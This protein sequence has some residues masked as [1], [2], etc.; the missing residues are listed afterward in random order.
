MKKIF[1]KIT[2]LLMLGASLLFVAGCNLDIDPSDSLT[3]DKMKTSPNGLTDVVNGCYTVFKD[4]QTGQGS[5]NWYLRQYYQLADF[6]SDDIVYGHETE[7]NLNMIFRYPERIASLDNFTTFWTNSYKIIYSANVA[8]ALASSA[9]EQTDL[10]KH[11]KG[12]A[13]FLKAYAMH[14]LVRLYAKPYTQVNPETD[15]GIIIRESTTD[16]ANKNRATLKETYDYIL[17]CLLEA[18]TTMDGITSDRDDSKGNVS[19]WAVRAELSRVYLYMG[20][21]DKAKEYATKVIESGKF[22][23]ETPA[24][25]PGYVTDASS[26]P[27]TIWCIKM[28][29]SDDKESGSVASMIMSEGDGCWGEEGYS[30]SLLADMGMGTNAQKADKRFQF[31]QDPVI[32]NGLTLYPCS[33]YS[34][35]DGKKTCASP[36]MIR[37]SEMYFNRAEA[38]ANTAAVKDAIAD[39][40]TV[41]EQRIDPTAVPG[42]KMEDYL[43][44]ESDVKGST[45]ALDLVLKEKR[46]EYCFEA[47]RFF[48]LMRYGKD[49][50]RNYWGFHILTYSVGQSTSSA[51]GLSVDQVVTK[52]SYD[53]LVF[54][55]PEQ[56]L[57]NNPECKQNA[58]Y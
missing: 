57:N 45:T 10:V 5:N 39:I 2:T 29:A 54:P 27:E 1:N 30:L 51:P 38:E 50:V 13:L 24:D 49:I 14:E 40:N 19:I 4:Y 41:R 31:V 58:G 8:Y 33:K 9:P 6:S 37:L 47:Q 3:G 44:K 55:I 32:K 21:W 48:D 56:E 52:A 46:I 23:L 12:E 20:N 11:L 28:I 18:E 42:T 25:I 26:A 17:K 7:D 43:Y 34:G 16:V 35:Q 53:R 36:I 22:T 15:L